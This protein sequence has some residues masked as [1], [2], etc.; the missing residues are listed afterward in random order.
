MR[1]AA[2]AGGEVRSFREQFE[3]VVRK[4]YHK[5]AVAELP[6]DQATKTD[7][8]R[9]GALRHDRALRAVWTVAVGATISLSRPFGVS[10]TNEIAKS[11]RV[12]Q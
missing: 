3:F 10:P 1:F 8:L 12:C 6:I 4:A 5:I 11:G 7:Q 2:V 9:E